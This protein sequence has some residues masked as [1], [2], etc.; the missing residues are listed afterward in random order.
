[1]F[2]KLRDQKCERIVG[3]LFRLY[4]FADIA[5]GIYRKYQVLPEGWKDELARLK[6]EGEPKL[7]WLNI[8]EVKWY[9]EVTQNY[10]GINDKLPKVKRGPHE[11]YEK[12][13][14]EFIENERNYF[15]KV[16]AFVK[17]YLWEVEAIAENRLGPKA[18][19]YLG[20]SQLQ[21]DYA[22][23]KLIQVHKCIE[24][25]LV[26]LEVLSLVDAPSKHK[27]GR[28]GYFA[29]TLEVQGERS[30][31]SYGEYNARYQLSKRMLEVLGEQ[32]SEHKLGHGELVK[33]LNFKE[34]W[35]EVSSMKETLKSLG[36][37][38][39]LI[40]PVRRFP[41]YGLFV[42]SV[43][44][45]L[46]ASHPAYEAI[47]KCYTKITDYTHYIDEQVT[48]KQEAEVEAFKRLTR[49]EY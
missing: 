33:H 35:Y 22:F 11:E 14:D 47:D 4:H 17:F 39:V 28:A 38:T 37:D 46:P 10:P 36:I 24:E 16:D 1:M 29:E 15:V 6:A 23:G 7:D 43:R 20:L 41:N 12:V 44:K 42:G 21:V 27:S 2:F 18:Q 13:I 49:E 8:A 5:K 30:K 19:E 40:A 25:L 32:V 34:L 3:D 26:S 45:K 48:L 9:N 31:K